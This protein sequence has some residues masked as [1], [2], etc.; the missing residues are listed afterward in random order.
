MDIHS[1]Q[2][3]SASHLPDATVILNSLALQSE[4]QLGRT[5]HLHCVF[6][7]TT[8]SLSLENSSPHTDRN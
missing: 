6:P 7:S 2:S 4:H 8:T 1:W 5:Q 3:G